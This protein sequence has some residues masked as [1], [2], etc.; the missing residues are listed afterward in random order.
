MCSSCWLVGAFLLVSRSLSLFSLVLHYSRSLVCFVLVSRSRILSFPLYPLLVTPRTFLS[1]FSPSFRLFIASH[2]RCSAT[3][4]RFPRFVFPLARTP[5]R[6]LSLHAASFL[7]SSFHHAFL[8]RPY[9][10][11][12]FSFVIEP[13]HIFSLSHLETNEER[14]TRRGR[15]R[16]RRAYFALAEETKAQ[17][18]VKLRFSKNLKT[19][20]RWGMEAAKGR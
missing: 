2:L 15:G 7:R 11:L 20:I 3:C 18:W 5:S 10:V 17:G 1:V 19:R 9:Y 8:R 6:S 4:I 14:E 12:L 16:R 13:R